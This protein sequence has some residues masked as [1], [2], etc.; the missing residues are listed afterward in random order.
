MSLI[1]T[2]TCTIQKLESK[3]LRGKPTYGDPIENIP[4]SIVRMKGTLRQTSVRADRSGSRARAM[5]TTDDVRLLIDREY[6][7]SLGDKITL[8]D[9]VLKVEDS[10]ARYDLFDRLDHHQVDCMVLNYES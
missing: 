7:V 8:K 10:Q 9:R 6:P 2:S 5:E 3:D 1:H 4:C